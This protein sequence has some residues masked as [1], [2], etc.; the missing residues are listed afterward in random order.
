MKHIRRVDQLSLVVT[1]EAFPGVELYCVERYARVTREGPPDYFFDNVI[2]EAVDE[3]EE[4]PGDGEDVGEQHVPVLMPAICRCNFRVDDPE[5]LDA[6]DAGI[7]E[8]DDDNEPVPENI[9]QP[10]HAQGNECEFSN[11]WGHEGICFRRQSGSA[12]RGASLIL[13]QSK[14]PIFAQ[15]WRRKGFWLQD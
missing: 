11:N 14:H 6:V 8:I 7:I 15:T 4:G 3:Q 10:A 5:I 12:N 13:W 1:H 2:V 9:P